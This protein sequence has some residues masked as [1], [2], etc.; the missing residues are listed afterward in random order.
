M[1]NDELLSKLDE[2]I[3]DYL[4]SI[5]GDATYEVFNYYIKMYKGIELK[6]IAS[7]SDKVLEALR[8]LFGEEIAKIVEGYSIM[9]MYKRFKIPLNK[10]ISLKQALE[11]LYKNI[12]K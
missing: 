6:D 8:T 2:I 12:N 4:R 10:N 7:K 11:L 3:N 5:L 9:A 1:V